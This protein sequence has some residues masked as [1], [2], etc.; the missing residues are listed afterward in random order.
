MNEKTYLVLE[1]GIVFEGF[2]M[3]ADGEVTGEIVFTT[4]MTGY[5]ETL[6]DK[7]YFGQ[8]IMHTYPLIG[9]YG[10]IPED[11]ESGAVSACG[12]IVKQVCYKPSN[13]RS[14]GDLDTFLKQR[15]IT[16]LCGIDTRELT[17]ILRDHG[18]MNGL[19]TKNPK[20]V[21]FNK[22]KAYAVKN[23]VERVSVK[24]KAVFNSNGRYTVV[25][26]DFG[27]KESIL[28]EL[29]KRNCRVIL[30]PH[31]TS[32]NAIID[33]KPDGIVLSNGPGDP[34]DNPVVI[35]N[36]KQL[37][38]S[39]VPIFGICLG[40]QLLALSHGFRTKKLKYGHRGVNQPV[41]D[42]NTGR[43]YTTS[44]NHG[45]FVTNESVDESAAKIW[46]INMNDETCE[47]LQYLNSPA[48]SVQFHP[49]GCAGPQ[50]T[51]F[52][53]DLFINKA[54]KYADA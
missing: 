31:D 25:L 45:Y 39:P 53:F 4:G 13:F 40:H 20:S 14:R 16:G 52:L 46:F 5:L 38:H 7:S 19:I 54:A 44:Q 3:G 28:K 51:G 9:N 10:V 48:F 8:I 17:K 35:N 50:D 27:Y 42:K 22:I 34:A 33:C 12:Y 15:N 49:E 11:F 1:N 6:T 26:V 29:V 30:L 36:I 2:S 23:A 24:E 37:I 18:T 41:K 43:I 32:A 21:D 47:G